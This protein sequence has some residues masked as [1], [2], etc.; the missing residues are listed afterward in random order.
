MISSTNVKNNNGNRSDTSVRFCKDV[1]IPTAQSL[2]HYENLKNPSLGVDDI[3]KLKASF[4]KSKRWP[5]FSTIVIEF[6]EGTDEQKSIVKKVVLDTYQP[7]INLT[8]KFVETGQSP[9]S[10]IRIAFD[11]NN[12]SWSNIGTDCLKVSQ[13]KVSDRFVGELP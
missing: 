4:V 10:D 13:K 8:L 1:M 2:E 12:G 7:L 6:L 11:H 3:R 9:R 5:Q